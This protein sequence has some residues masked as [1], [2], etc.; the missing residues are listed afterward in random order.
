[1]LQMKM[2]WFQEGIL[3]TLFSLGGGV[4]KIIFTLIY[5]HNQ[6]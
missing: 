1:M 3:L 2:E 4:K 5:I 6:N